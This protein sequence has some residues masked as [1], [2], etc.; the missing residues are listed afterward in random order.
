MNNSFSWKSNYNV[1][2]SDLLDH[3]GD[4]LVQVAAVEFY[5]IYK[6]MEEVRRKSYVHPEEDKLC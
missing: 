3:D 2:L 5:Q 1:H 6:Y 4:I